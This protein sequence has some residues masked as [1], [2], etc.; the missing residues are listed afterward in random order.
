MDVFFIYLVMALFFTLPTIVVAGA[1][2]FEIHEGSIRRGIGYLFA[3]V[4]WIS[5]GLFGLDGQLDQ[6]QTHEVCDKVGYIYHEGRCFTG[7]VTFG[8]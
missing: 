5:I 6:A 7:E 2:L 8:E 3:A 1:G 4:A